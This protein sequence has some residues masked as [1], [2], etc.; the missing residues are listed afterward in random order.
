MT[1]GRR[2]VP[3][4]RLGRS[5]ILPGR[6]VGFANL[7]IAGFIPNRVDSPAKLAGTPGGGVVAIELAQE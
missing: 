3:T 7:H 2:T 1:C 6:R 4:G 5:G